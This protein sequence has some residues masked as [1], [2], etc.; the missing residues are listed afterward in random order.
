MTESSDANVLM[1][2]VR[3]ALF[4]P[5]LFKELARER[6][7]IAELLE[8]RELELTPEQEEF[9]NEHPD[10]VARLYEF[11]A[12][13]RS[14]SPAESEALRL[15]LA[16]RDADETAIGLAFKNGLC[17][18]LGPLAD[19]TPFFNELGVPRAPADLVAVLRTRKDVEAAQPAVEPLLRFGIT[20][21][22]VYLTCDAPRTLAGREGLTDTL[23][24][25][26]DGWPRNRRGVLHATDVASEA[27][28]LNDS[29]A[30]PYV[31]LFNWLRELQRMDQ[32]TRQYMFRGFTTIRE[33][34]QL[35]LTPLGGNQL[36]QIDPSLQWE[37]QPVEELVGA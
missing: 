22:N 13:E 9:L 26:P 1:D 24:I 27:A 17:R 12:D 31:A 23:V 25:V 10:G 11:L 36:S 21:M 4:H 5:E 19:A 15:A 14:A 33:G 35:R 6:A 7:A 30:T 28:M 37:P 18:D 2:R 34:E 16:V 20:P 8:G 3:R 29:E 32:W